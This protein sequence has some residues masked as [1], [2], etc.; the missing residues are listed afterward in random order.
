MGDIAKHP[1][2][3]GTRTIADDCFDLMDRLIARM[4]VEA[5]CI[6]LSRQSPPL[7]ERDADGILAALAG[8]LDEVQHE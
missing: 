4:G 5:Y 8:K 2:F 3:G 7:D 1:L 6:W